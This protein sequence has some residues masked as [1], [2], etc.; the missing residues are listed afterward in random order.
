MHEQ[1]LMRGLHECGYLLLQGLTCQLGKGPQK[2]HYVPE[3]C[4]ASLPLRC[5][6]CRCQEL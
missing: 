5:R 6:S 4:S 1:W 3:S 2:K